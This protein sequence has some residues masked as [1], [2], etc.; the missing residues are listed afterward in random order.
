ML[1]LILE[2]VEFVE[3]FY[4]LFP[5][6]V[7]ISSLYQDYVCTDDLEDISRAEYIKKSDPSALRNVVK[8][9]CRNEANYVKR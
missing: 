3:N 4:L 6:K 5:K 9:L 8:E 2:F 1:P 7:E